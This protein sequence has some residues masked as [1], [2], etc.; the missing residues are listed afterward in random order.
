MATTP[1]QFDLPPDLTLTLEL[2][3]FGTPTVIANGAGGDAAP[4]LANNKGT[5]QADVTEALVGWYHARAKDGSGNTIGKGWV[6]LADTTAVHRVH[7][8]P[9]ELFDQLDAIEAKTTLIG[10]GTTEV[11]QPVDPDSGDLSLTQGDDH[12]SG[13]RIPRWTIE[14]WT[15]PDMTGAPAHLRLVKISVYNGQTN[16]P[17]EL[18]VTGGTCTMV[19][20]DLVVEVPITAAQSDTLTASWNEEEVT[21]RYQV[22]SPDGG[23]GN[24]EDTTIARGDAYVVRKVIP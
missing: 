4:Q 1:V 8:T 20:S 13:D 12:L 23:S 15:G 22:F 10:S 5:Y 6:E 3:A 21:H 16:G 14:D 9:K 24:N 7:E 17:A 19:G 2:Y 18:V 11:S